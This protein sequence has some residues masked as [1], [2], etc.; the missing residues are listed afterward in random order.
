MKPQARSTIPRLEDQNH[1]K[2]RVINARTI[3]PWSHAIIHSLD[4]KQASEQAFWQS[5]GAAVRDKGYL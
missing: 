3:P 1:N 2:V 5:F 4:F